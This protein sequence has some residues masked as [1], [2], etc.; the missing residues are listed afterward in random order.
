MTQITY[1]N[2]NAEERTKQLRNAKVEESSIREW[3]TI[4]FENLPQPVQ[5]K[6]NASA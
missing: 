4:Q 2:A 3:S 6:L 1:N 5:E